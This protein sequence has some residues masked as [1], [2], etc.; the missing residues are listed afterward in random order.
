MAASTATSSTTGQP[1]WRPST[2]PLRRGQRFHQQVQ[3]AFLL[4]LAGATARPEHHVKLS[5]VGRGRVDLHVV[6][7]LDDE[8]YAVVIEIKSTDWDALAGHR[9]RPNLRAHIRQLQAYLDR[10]LDDMDAAVGNDDS[11]AARGGG[12]DSVSGVLLYPR[13]PTSAARLQLIDDLTSREAIMVA[14]YDEADWT[15]PPGTTASP[16]Q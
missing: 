1:V 12:W 7:D 14:W 16:V 4:G 5:R 11:A 10:Y 2:A 3:T 9:V 13:R 15:S 6:P 8:R